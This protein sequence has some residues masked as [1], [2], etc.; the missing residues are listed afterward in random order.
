MPYSDA[1]FAILDATSSAIVAVTASGVIDYANQEA[2]V[3]FGYTQDELLG[4]PVETLMPAASALQHAKLREGYI[5]DARPRAM[6]SGLELAAQRKDGTTFPVEISLTPLPTPDGPWTLA[7]IVDISA[8]RAAETRVRRMSRAHLA[9][10]ELNAEILRAQTPADLF[11]HVCQVIAAVSTQ[12][13]TWVAAPDGA[14][15]LRVDCSVGDIGPMAGGD[16]DPSAA[17]PPLLSVLV[18]SAPWFCRDLAA[19]V[20]G[21]WVEWARAEGVRTV[22]ALPLRRASRAVA[23]LVIQAHDHTLLEE[24]LV[25]V[26]VTMA[27]N[28]SFALDRLDSQAQLR[29][30]DAQRVDLLNRLVAAQEEERARIAA[31]VHDHSIQSLAAIDLRLGLLRTRIATAA[32]EL[33]ASVDL[34]QAAVSEVTGGLRHLLFE[35]EVADPGVSLVDQLR[36]AL[37][38]VFLDESVAT[39]LRWEDGADLAAVPADAD[40]PPTTRRH[41]VRI[42]REALVNVRRHAFASHVVIAI[43][44]DRDGV[45]IAV[46]DDGVGPSGDLTT[47]RSAHGHRGLNGMRDRAQVVGGWCRLERADGHT[48]LRFWLPRA[49]SSPAD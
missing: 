23:V 20:S 44:P 36:D 21:P 25:S 41:A 12:V 6:G 5:A 42:C 49:P 14:S 34:L 27:D 35:L 16:L 4:R 10:A 26:L 48:T 46:I 37:D 40:L 33:A 17:I 32:P 18:N 43:R 15:R 7:G 11:L 45:E 2:L 47:L 13:S 24:E 29:R 39:A 9:L 22:V 8:R 19:E 28:V 3:A 30:F 38:Y 1:L 31:D